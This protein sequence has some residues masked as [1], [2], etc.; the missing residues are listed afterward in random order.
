MR[1]GPAGR[2]GPSVH[3]GRQPAGLGADAFLLGPFHA[4][5]QA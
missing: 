5:W 4:Y 3:T 2:P 1:R